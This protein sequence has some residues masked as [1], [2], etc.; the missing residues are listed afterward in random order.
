MI[1]L[2]TNTE[3]IY[4]LSSF[5]A[6][7][8]LDKKLATDGSTIAFPINLL[9]P[10]MLP[11]NW[12]HDFLWAHVQSIFTGFNLENVSNHHQGK[13]PQDI[14]I[15]FKRKPFNFK[16]IPKLL[17]TLGCCTLERAGVG[18]VDTVQTLFCHLYP[19]TFLPQHQVPLICQSSTS[20]EVSGKQNFIFPV[21]KP[22]KLFLKDYR[23]AKLAIIKYHACCGELI[24]TSSL[25]PG[26][27]ETA[28]EGAPEESHTS[29]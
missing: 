25:P 29:R 18:G 22:L 6:L 2:P 24:A 7:Q 20:H 17:H 13:K 19:S 21:S 11:L 8:S 4:C 10:L 12:H 14:G 5:P 15:R 27:R 28:G 16:G 26:S 9:L 1:S 3:D 23:K